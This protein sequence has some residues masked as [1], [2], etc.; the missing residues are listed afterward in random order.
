MENGANTFCT[1]TNYISCTLPGDKMLPTVG[2]DASFFRNF[3][4][5][6]M[7]F[8]GCSGRDLVWK[9]DVEA[10]DHFRRCGRKPQ[11]GSGQRR[12]QKGL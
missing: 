8:E 1:R 2:L 3:S 12:W 10:R 5:G 6:V 7:D 11:A 4:C 9:M